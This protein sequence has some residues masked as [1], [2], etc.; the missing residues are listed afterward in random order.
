MDKN[1]GKTDKNRARDW[2]EREKTRP[3]RSQKYFPS[4][5]VERGR[6]NESIGILYGKSWIGERLNE[7]RTKNIII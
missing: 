6:K 3:R 4:S 7:A 2:K 5:P 1:Q